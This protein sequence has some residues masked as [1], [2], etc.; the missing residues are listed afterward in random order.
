MEKLCLQ[1]I[2]TDEQ[3]DETTNRV[4]P[5]YPPYTL[6]AW[7]L[8]RINIEPIGVYVFIHALKLL[9]DLLNRSSAVDASG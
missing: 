7:V 4:I 2:W 8:K 1:D 3:R 5:L 9:I 6:F